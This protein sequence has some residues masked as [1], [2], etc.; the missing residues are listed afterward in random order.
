MD[1]S[2]VSFSLVLAVLVVVMVGGGD[3]GGKA[4]GWAVNK[5]RGRKMS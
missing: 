1:Q 4:C 2:E 5:K 3:D